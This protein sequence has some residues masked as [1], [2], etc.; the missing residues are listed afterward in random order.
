[1]QLS[2]PEI[3]CSI[4]QKR[5]ALETAKT[6]EFGQAVHEGCY[7]LKLGIRRDQDSVHKLGQMQ[8]VDIPPSPAVGRYEK[9][10]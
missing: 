6:D 1:M 5:V 7:V 2:E 9:R 8:T 4:C 10:R 3:N